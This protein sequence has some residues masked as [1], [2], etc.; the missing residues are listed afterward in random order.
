[1]KSQVCAVLVVPFLMLAGCT[2]QP[3]EADGSAAL[4]S[5]ISGL[6]GDAPFEITSFTKT[7]GQ[8]IEVMGAKGYRLYYTATV[9]FPSGFK[10]SCLN[11]RSDAASFMGNVFCAAEFGGPGGGSP[12]GPQASGAVVTYAGEVDFQKTE[13]RWLAQGVSLKQ[14]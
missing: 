9:S 13:N 14:Q 6:I 11:R 8:S 10:S 4:R 5:R 12:V 2:S 7:D 1:M 3:A